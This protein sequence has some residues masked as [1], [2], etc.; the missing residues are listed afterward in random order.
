MANLCNIT[1]IDILKLNNKFIILIGERHEDIMCNN[2]KITVE[3][4]FNQ[5][6][7]ILKGFR[8]FVEVPCEYIFYHRSED[9]E[10]RNRPKDKYNMYYIYSNP[11]NHPNIKFMNYD[12]RDKLYRLF[13]FNSEY[14]LDVLIFNPEKIYNINKYFII[15]LFCNY[16]A[17]NINFLNKYITQFFLINEKYK[18]FI[19]E[20]FKNEFYEAIGDTP[21]IKNISFEDRSISI[22][23]ADGNYVFSSHDFK[24]IAFKEKFDMQSYIRTF[25]FNKICEIVNVCTILLVEEDQIYYF[26]STH[27]TSISMFFG[28]FIKKFPLN[29]KDKSIPLDESLIRNLKGIIQK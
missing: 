26:G 27:I 3:S 11:S 13:A 20:Y 16:Y 7:P 12:Y 8:G 22:T 4:L 28:Q 24:S 15:T 23:F 2:S 6:D 17:Y 14:P 10:M 5:L 21:R 1:G 9:T 29:L 25:I 18:S 19:V